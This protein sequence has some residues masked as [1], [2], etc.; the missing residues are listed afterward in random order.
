VRDVLLDTSF[1]V[2]PFETS[3]HPFERLRDRHTGVQ[4]CTLE[5][6][7]QEARS[8]RSGRY[9]DSVP[10]LIDHSEI[11]VL[12]TEGE[13]PVDDLLVELSDSFVVA[14]NDRELRRRIDD[15]GGATVY[16]RS[17]DHL[18]QGP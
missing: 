15:A 8:I 14:T 16:V 6:V 2:A 1:L 5:D 12:E 17:G 13:G 7:I 4:L 11:Q 3:F 18:E 10:D 9:A